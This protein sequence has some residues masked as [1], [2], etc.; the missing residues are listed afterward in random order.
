MAVNTQGTII[1]FDCV[2]EMTTPH[3]V[4]LTVVGGVVTSKTLSYDT[5]FTYFTKQL[6]K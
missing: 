5:L 6:Q 3:I 4:L 1:T 2:S